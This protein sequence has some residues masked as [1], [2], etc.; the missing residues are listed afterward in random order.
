VGFVWK[1]IWLTT[2]F[3]INL[4][5]HALLPKLFPARL[6]GSVTL[7]RATGLGFVTLVVVP[8]A[9]LLLMLTLIGLPADLLIL[10]L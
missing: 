9:T 10:K 6:P 4:A 2:A 1:L 7:L 8:A 3:L 5:L